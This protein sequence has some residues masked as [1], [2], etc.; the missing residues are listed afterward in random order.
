MGALA[1]L[2]VNLDENNL[3]L[4]VSLYLSDASEF[5]PFFTFMM[6]NKIPFTQASSIIYPHPTLSEAIGELAAS[7]GEKSRTLH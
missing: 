5:L 7:I 6:E 1:K 4:G 2:S 3:I